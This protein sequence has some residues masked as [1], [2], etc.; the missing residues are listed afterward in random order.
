MPEEWLSKTEP[1]LSADSFLAASR[2]LFPG[3]QRPRP[4]ARPEEKQKSAAPPESAAK[5]CELRARSKKIGENA[6]NSYL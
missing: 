1:G 3:P 2:Q 6:D 4:E 5:K